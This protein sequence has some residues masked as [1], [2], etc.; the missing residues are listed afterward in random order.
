MLLAAAVGSAFTFGIKFCP[1]PGL[2]SLYLVIS[3]FQ[4]VA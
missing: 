1:H 4:Q 2:G 3:L